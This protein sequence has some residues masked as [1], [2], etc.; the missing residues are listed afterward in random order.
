MTEIDA[1]EV[2]GGRPVVV[3]AFP[4]R[5]RARDRLHEQLGEVDLI[6]IRESVA[7]ADLVLVPSCSPQTISGL[8]AAYPTAQLVVVEIDDWDLGVDLSGPVMRLLRAGADRYLTANSVDQL[9]E[10][11]GARLAASDADD[12]DPQRVAALPS[13]TVDDIILDRLADLRSRRG[14][15]V[16]QSPAVTDEGRRPA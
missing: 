15:E 14:S 11:L 4:L 10:Q 2:F 8:K 12:V 6:D 5:Q 9:A 1:V 16:H 3:T 13:A 7:Q